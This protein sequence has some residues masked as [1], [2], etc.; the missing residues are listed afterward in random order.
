MDCEL[1]EKNLIDLL[2]GELEESATREMRAH[3]EAC[4]ACRHAYVKLEA[5]R[6]FS[7]KLEL[8]PA[9]SLASVLAAARVQAAANRAAREPVS[10]PSAPAPAPTEPTEDL[11]GPPRLLRRPAPLPLGPHRAVSTGLLPVAPIP[12]LA[13]PGPTRAATR[14]AREAGGVYGQAL[15]RCSS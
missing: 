2:Y 14:R 1:C 9:P 11:H 6:A 3:L 12:P 15:A 8:A 13:R 7:R 5:G 10:V 4:D